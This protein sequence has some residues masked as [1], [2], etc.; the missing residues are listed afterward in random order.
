MV[1][2]QLAKQPQDLPLY[3]DIE[4]RGRLVGHHEFRRSANAI[5]IS[6]RCRMPPDS[7]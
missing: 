7:S 4:C 1:P 6:T 2:L 5:A 3:R